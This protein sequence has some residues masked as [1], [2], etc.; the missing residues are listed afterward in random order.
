MPERE[1]SGRNFAYV[2][3]A[4]H[5]FVYIN[6]AMLEIYPKLS[7][8]EVCHGA[9]YGSGSPCPVCPLDENRY[10]EH[11]V[12][13]PVL[14]QWVSATCVDVEWP[15]AGPCTMISCA[16]IQDVN[17]SIMSRLPY[18]AGY[19]VFFEMNLTRDRFRRALRGQEA[20]ESQIEEEPLSDLLERTA[21]HLVHPLDYH[22]FKRFW[23]FSTMMERIAEAGGT[24]HDEFVERNA[25]GGWDLV[26]TTIVPEKAYLSN[27]DIIVAMYTV[28]RSPQ[29]AQIALMSNEG[30]EPEPVEVAKGDRTELG[31]IESAIEMAERAEQIIARAYPGSQCVM[32]FDIENFRFFNRW[33]GR[34]AGDRLL[35]DIV[36]YLRAVEKMCCTVVARCSADGFALI[37]PNDGKLLGKIQRELR[38]IVQSASGNKGFRLGVGFYLVLDQEVPFPDMVDCALTAATRSLEDYGERLSWYD[39]ERAR[40]QERMWE[41]LPDLRHALEEDQFKV[42]FQPKVAMDTGEVVGAEA[43]VRWSHPERGVLSPASFIPVLEQTGEVTKLDQLVWRKTFAKVA[44]WIAEGRQVKPISVNVSRRDFR[45]IDVAHALISLS[46]EFGV[47]PSL[48]VIEITEGAFA[49]DRAFANDPI[50]LLRAQGFTLLIDDFGSGY[51]SLNMLKD[52]AADGLKIDLMFLGFG[53]E[54]AERGLSIIRSVVDMAHTLGIPVTV[55][56]VETQFQVDALL[57]MGCRLAQGYFYH[58]P[59][60]AEKFIELL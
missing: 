21:E 39:T 15:G 10:G 1:F 20:R 57:E 29:L 40:E 7:V 4:G 16:L 11:I 55:E 24:L 32:A 43:L 33:L 45:S 27:E 23:D 22:R 31:D 53:E 9:I 44:E 50:N 49:E 41:M 6:E 52:I 48:V 12:F 59:L 36:G 35:E 28:V 5:R 13:N 58:K 37:L 56:G 19:D 47:D 42:Y 2:I 3:D 30:L 26:H 51:S 38:D 8:G 34:D 17:S 54:N 46:E 25:K 18:M 60:P 14:D